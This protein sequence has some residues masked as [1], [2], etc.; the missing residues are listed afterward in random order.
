MFIAEKNSS[1]CLKVWCK[2]KVE[3]GIQDIGLDYLY[4]VDLVF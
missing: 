1:R 4:H 3:D 2:G